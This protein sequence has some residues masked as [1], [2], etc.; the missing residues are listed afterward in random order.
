MVENEP[1]QLY[2]QEKMIEQ[3]I[4]GSYWNYQYANFSKNNQYNLQNFRVK[5]NSVQNK[6]PIDITNYEMISYNS[7]RLTVPKVMIQAFGNLEMAMLLAEYSRLSMYK[8]VNKYGFYE[9]TYKEIQTD[10]GLT[11]YQQRK[12]SKKL[13]ELG[14]IDIVAYTKEMARFYRFNDNFAR[15]QILYYRRKSYKQTPY[16]DKQI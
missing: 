4:K 5:D 11:E 2:I 14:Y 16:I 7:P 9:V 12:Y 3:N 10:T 8:D 15:D 13:E 6:N 1:E